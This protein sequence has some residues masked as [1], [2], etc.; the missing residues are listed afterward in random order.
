VTRSLLEYGHAGARGFA[1]VRRLFYEQVDALGLSHDQA[2]AALD[3]LTSELT[4]QWDH[5]RRS[6]VGSGGT[7]EEEDLSSSRRSTSGSPRHSNSAVRSKGSPATVAA[8]AG[9]ARGAV[10]SP[11]RAVA[12]PPAALHDLLARVVDVMYGRAGSSDCSAH[13]ASAS[14][15]AATTASDSSEAG[16]LASIV[17]AA[18]KRRQQKQRQRRQLAFGMRASFTLRLRGLKCTLMQLTYDSRAAASVADLVLLDPSGIQLLRFCTG[19]SSADFTSAA[20]SDLAEA[21]AAA[22][23]ASDAAAATAAAAVS[24]DAE[25]SVTLQLRR[26]AARRRL[27]RARQRGGGDTADSAAA[28]ADAAA[29]A[30]AAREQ[31]EAAAAAAAQAR[32]GLTALSLTV[33]TQDARHVWGQGGDAPKALSAATAFAV[34]AGRASP[35]RAL[36]RALQRDRERQVTLT[37]DKLEVKVDPGSLRSAMLALFSFVEGAQRAVEAVEAGSS[38]SNS[39]T[40]AAAASAATEPAA[41]RPSLLALLPRPSLRTGLTCKL[42]QLDVLLSLHCRPFAHIRLRGGSCSLAHRQWWTAAARSSSSSSSKQQSHLQYLR[43]S[44]QSL[45][46]YDLTPDGQAHDE[47]ITCKSLCSHAAA[48]A[49]A[50]AAGGSSSGFLMLALDPPSPGSTA[51][52]VLS[53]RLDGLRVCFL[54]R[55]ILELTEYLGRWGMEPVLTLAT[56]LMAALSPAATVTTPTAGVTAAAG[57]A[58]ATAAE[59]A[60]AV[61][62]AAAAGPGLSIRISLDDLALICPRNT[63]SAEAVGV[64]VAAAVVEV[65]RQKTTWSLPAD[66]TPLCRKPRHSADA[67][68]TQSAEPAAATAAAAEPLAAATLQQQQQ[69]RPKLDVK[70]SALSLHPSL[71]PPPIAVLQLSATSSMNGSSSAAES[72]QSQSSPADWATPPAADELRSLRSAGF[73]GGASSSKLA[74]YSSFASARS[75]ERGSHRSGSH[76]RLRSGG[77][78]DGTGSGS[79]AG[80]SDLDD[81]FDADQGVEGEWADAVD[82]DAD[83]ADRA[84]LYEEH[85]YDGSDS[86]SVD[87]D[88]RSNSSGSSN[89][90][91]AFVPQVP[92]AW[93]SEEVPVTT[94]S[95]AVRRTG[96]FLGG[97]RIFCALLPHMEPPLHDRDPLIDE[98]TGEVKTALQKAWAL[99]D[100]APVHCDTAASS[101]YRVDESSHSSS[102]SSGTAASAEQLKWTEVTEQPCD[103][104][105]YIDAGGGDGSSPAR[106]L[107]ALA[108]YSQ[109]DV[110]A[111]EAEGTR[112]GGLYI[113]P[114]MSAYCLLLSSYFDNYCELPMFYG[115]LDAS[116]WPVVPLPQGL[117]SW[118][119]Y[120]TPAMIGRVLELLPKWSFC[121]SVPVFEARVAVD[122]AY[123]DRP[124]DS[125]WMAG[126]FRAAAAAATPAEAAAAAIAAAA[127]PVARMRFTNLIVDISGGGGEALRLH[128]GAGDCVVVDV[129]DPCRSVHPV[130]LHA[131]AEAALAATSAPTCAATAGDTAQLARVNP[132]TARQGY[133]DPLFGYV[134]LRRS[135]LAPEQLAL[136]LQVSVLMTTADKWVSVAVGV[137][138]PDMN[139]KDLALVWL[140]VDIFSL[141]HRFEEYGCPFPA[142]V[143]VDAVDVAAAAGLTPGVS[144]CASPSPRAAAASSTA[145]A[146]DRYEACSDLGGSVPGDAQLQQLLLQQQAQAGRNIDVRVWVARPHIAALEHPLSAR[147]AALLLEAEGLYYRWQWLNG[148][149]RVHMEA[150][151]AGLAAVVLNSYA[152]AAR[153]RGVR[154]TAGS[155]R[156]VRTL[157]EHLSLGLWLDQWYADNRLDLHVSLPLPPEDDGYESDDVADG[158]ADSAA[159]ATAT[160]AA[161]GATAGSSSLLRW[162][163]DA[164]PPEL[165]LPELCFPAPQAVQASDM[166]NPSSE[167][168]PRAGDIVTSWED[169]LFA[170]ATATVFLGPVPD[171]STATAA[172][173]AATAAS[174]A[175]TSATP[176]AGRSARRASMAAAGAAAG[177]AGVSSS[178]ADRSS[179][180][181]AQRESWQ[182]DE[183]LS[184]SLAMLPSTSLQVCATVH[185]M[186][187][188]YAAEVITTASLLLKLLMLQHCVE[189]RKTR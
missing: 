143:D 124:L 36:A 87:D 90:G 4:A 155:G 149:Q 154:G 53:V 169:L 183:V 156:G 147:T 161:T 61:P 64:T 91:A 130:V 72:V 93:A 142:E 37:T 178:G 67:G 144:R 184:A 6:F 32:A 71:R 59:A 28:A 116:Y 137:D 141:Y 115:P 68:V 81:F 17:E 145:G 185:E 173:A 176:A 170:V 179:G 65:A 151:I 97:T 7:A 167:L 152:G 157:A 107:L 159:A 74:Q 100:G 98:A 46:V 35:G 31:L 25:D 40:A 70:K 2:A 22:S 18:L 57:E 140:L 126:D 101:S 9:S 34:A 29:E 175:A 14:A 23:A 174:T 117:Q 20:Q 85:R 129:R 127:L 86:G 165:P 102:S 132:L 11:A 189:L 180:S 113:R 118:P 133:A 77:R 162:G 41:G 109:A 60:A 79:D 80:S 58:S 39:S 181:A 99:A 110:A 56:D 52:G 45:Q 134:Q 19:D 105:M 166:A 114:A 54:G 96:V 49:A 187:C 182:E 146:A 83:A 55:F 13:G 82:Y 33:S 26:L 135:A 51:A 188:K 172:A 3:L 136:P 106:T 12:P 153:A 73:G 84:A 139:A 171:S 88:A 75:L 123:F 15:V 121:V 42:G 43:A 27:E 163:F 10:G 16:G 30:L 125:T 63:H 112:A 150:T 38:V 120:G 94:S 186:Y 47:V 111:C 122:T 89:S 5:D 24:E 119:A 103:L 21:A 8:A 108:E 138:A 164:P 50:P 48:A 104:V 78:T 95:G 158:D 168:G 128:A 148:P 62:V 44:A 1:H 177:G 69:Q 76:R 66:D 160:A 131:G 92:R